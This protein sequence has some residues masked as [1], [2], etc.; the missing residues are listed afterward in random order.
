M[1]KRY[2]S[3]N[4]RVQSLSHVPFSLLLVPG[5][6]THMFIREH[7][8]APLGTETSRRTLDASLMICVGSMC[9]ASASAFPKTL[10]AHRCSRSSPRMCQPQPQGGG[11]PRDGDYR[12]HVV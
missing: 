4:A 12:Q 3:P 11:Q 7:P 9:M 6:F 8:A 2:V 1:R 5:T 10:T